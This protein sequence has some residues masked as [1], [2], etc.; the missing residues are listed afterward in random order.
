[1]R[2]RVDPSRRSLHVSTDRIE[3]RILL[4]APPQR[5][6]RALTDSTEFGRWFGM[7]FDGPFT[8]GA[9]MR[10]VIV[11]TTVDADVAKTQQAYEGK[12]FEI[13][14]ELGM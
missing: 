14:I 13:T 1:M 9:L 6:W 2:L 7:R 8:P 12:S 5:V 11:P 4:R 3:K 10:G